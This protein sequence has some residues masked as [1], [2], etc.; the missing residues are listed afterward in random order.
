MEGTNNKELIRQV[1]IEITIRA[2][3][4]FNGVKLD[5]VNGR[6]PMITDTAFIIIPLPEVDNAIR[7][8]SL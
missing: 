8:A 1:V 4:N 7:A 6:N 3:K 2:P 5:K